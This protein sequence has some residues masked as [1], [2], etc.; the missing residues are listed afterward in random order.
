MSM[1]KLQME[2]KTY[3]SGKVHPNTSRARQTDDPGAEALHRL[4]GLHVVGNTSKPSKTSLDDRNGLLSEGVSGCINTNTM[5][6]QFTY[7]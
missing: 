3:K 2:R 4:N 6:L 1:R 5:T 7:L